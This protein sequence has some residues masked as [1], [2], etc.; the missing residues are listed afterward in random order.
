[1]IRIEGLFKKFHAKRV[2]RGVDLEIEKG[3]TMV[4]IGRSG[5]G[6][7]VLLKSIINLVEPDHGAVWFNQH[8]ISMAREK[9]K[10]RIRQHFGMLFQGS[11]LFDSLTVAENVCF[12]LRRMKKLSE[13]QID[14]IVT[15]RLA[16]VGLKNIEQHYP[17]ELS[18]GMKKR[19]ALAR[20]I[21]LDPEVILY[22][23][24]TT[25]I[26]P[27]MADAIND[28]IISLRKKLSVTSIVV[29]HDMVSAYKIADRIAMLHEGK[30]VG[31]GTPA[32]IKKTRNPLIRQFISG[33]AHGPIKLV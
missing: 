21:A 3:E 18:G 24:P 32:R 20:A 27:I 22:D 15:E 29:T 33:S 12:G 9:E 1:M 10:D 6:K 2:L 17:A 28:L 25:G 4:I 16:M 23:E 7:S 26:D 30:I 8:N 31:V 19:V 13:T 11:A 14:K 5:E